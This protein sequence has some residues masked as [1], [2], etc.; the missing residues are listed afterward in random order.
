[1]KQDQQ[2]T[3][4]SDRGLLQKLL[5]FRPGGSSEEDSSLSFP[6]L[7]L[8]MSEYSIHVIHTKVQIPF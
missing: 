7:S 2:L 6:S 3:T 5:D 4:T 1:M 8:D